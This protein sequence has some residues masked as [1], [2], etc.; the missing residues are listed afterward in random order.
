M[1]LFFVQP[2]LVSHAYEILFFF[3][4]LELVGGLGEMRGL[5]SITMVALMIP[6]ALAKTVPR[7]GPN[8]MVARFGGHHPGWVVRDEGMNEPEPGGMVLNDVSLYDLAGGVFV[9]LIDGTL[10]WYDK[11]RFKDTSTNEFLPLVHCGIYDMWDDPRPLKWVFEEL[12]KP[13]WD[14]TTQ[15]W[16]M[17]VPGVRSYV[18]YKYGYGIETESQW[19]YYE[20]LQKLPASMR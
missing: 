9:R 10:V 19:E 2:L 11:A 14:A 1:C 8:A 5:I 18:N 20:R 3:P 15:D 13:V 7:P 12:P 4:C 6:M 16:R 17:Q